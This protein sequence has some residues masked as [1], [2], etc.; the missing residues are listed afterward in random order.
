MQEH[1]ELVSSLTDGDNVFRLL[2]ESVRDYAIFHLDP[3]GYVQ[4][5]NEGARRIKGYEA[6]EIIGRHFSVFYQPH[7]ARQGK[8]AYELVVAADEGHWEEEGWRVRKDGTHFWAHVVITALYDHEDQ[9]VGYAKVTRD[10]TERKLAE[11]QRI[12]MLERERRAREEADQALEELHTIQALTETALTHLD[13]EDVI[14]ELLELIQEFIQVDTVVMLLLDHEKTILT[15]MAALGIDP[16]TR[17]TLRTPVGWGYTGKVASEQRSIIVTDVTQED[18]FD[19]VL[20]ELGINSWLGVP[21]I[22]E[23]RTLGVLHV[24]AFYHR[25]FGAREERFLQIVADRL[26]LAIDRARLIRSEQEAR[27]EA[28]T[29]D[30]KLRAQDAFLA[31]AAHELRSPTA[32]VK[33]AVQVLMRR[34]IAQ[35]DAPRKAS[36]LPLL[37]TADQQADRLT[38]VVDKLI[39]SARIDSGRLG[40]DLVY[41]DV[42]K[43]VKR[44]VET[45]CSLAGSPRVVV[46]GPN[47]LW[48]R[49]DPV[50]VEEVI[51]NVLENAVRHSGSD[52]IDIG[53]GQPQPEHW[54]LAVRD[55]GT[56]VP[57]EH[58]D[59]L[60]RRFYQYPEGAAERGLGLGLYV[61]QE[62]VAQHGGRLDINFPDDSGMLVTMTLPIRGEL[63]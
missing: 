54:E 52:R 27:I 38:R 25:N 41:T 46:S 45:S 48:A 17:N 22:T 43:L 42:V 5:W 18:A 40:L 33:T 7:E 34:I 26:A 63:A 14:D 6:S 62:V 3:R 44:A 4:S 37:E 35:A 49:V 24:G 29:A 56:G 55:Y 23:N 31:V 12:L 8:P 59:F 60:L 10:L 32:S 2:V 53:I 58:R 50:R 11:E 36:W 15:P 61:C 47:S 9:L 1:V 28:E 39:E 13:L 30:A 51:S 20:S 21:L 19:P 57:A 16:L